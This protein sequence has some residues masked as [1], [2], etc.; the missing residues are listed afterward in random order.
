MH[1][2]PD[3]FDQAPDRAAFRRPAGWPGVELYRAHIVHHH[4]APHLHD[5]YGLGVVEAGAERFRYRGREH[6]AAA[7]AIV[8]MQPGELHTGGPAAPGGWRYRML[9]LDAPTLRAQLGDGAP[10]DWVFERAVHEEPARA[11]DLA[12]T[13]ARLWDAVDAGES[14]AADAAL[15]DALAAL[16]PLT[17]RPTDRTAALPADAR[18]FASVVDALHADLPRDWRLAELAA[19]AGL[20]PF[21]FQRAFQAAHGVS[22]HQW[23]MALRLAEAKRLLA[24]GEPPAAVAAAVGLADQAHL[25]RRFAGMYGITPARYQRGLRAA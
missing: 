16:A 9:Y 4:F 2:V 14:L 8:L 13:L 24:R 1:G 19:L 25:T 23:R 5:G 10:G 15:A 7:G 18:P 22:A 11:R 12:A 20:S 3:H 17:S 6:L 21:H